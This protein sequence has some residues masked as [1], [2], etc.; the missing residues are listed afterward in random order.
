MDIDKLFKI[1]E[2]IPGG[3]TYSG[4]CSYQ[5]CFPLRDG[6]E[7]RFCLTDSDVAEFD[8]DSEQTES[9]VFNI[10]LYDGGLPPCITGFSKKTGKA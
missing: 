6:G 4:S 10:D 8:K 2:K 5:I 3:Y 7:L 9:G 1:L